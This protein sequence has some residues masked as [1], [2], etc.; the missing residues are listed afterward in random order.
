MRVETRAMSARTAIDE[1]G[2]KGEFRR[3]DALFRDFIEEGG[4]FPPESKGIGVMWLRVDLGT[5]L[6]GM[7]GGRELQ[8]VSRGFGFLRRM[9]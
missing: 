8:D 7:G 5:L 4:R 9:E 1:M 6:C 2:V 3:S